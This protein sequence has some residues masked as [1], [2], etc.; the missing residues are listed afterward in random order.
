MKTFKKLMKESILQSLSEEDSYKGGHQKDWIIYDDDLTKLFCIAILNEGDGWKLIE[1]V[2][3]F[4]N[5]NEILKMITIGYETMI[6]AAKDRDL[7]EYVIGK[8]TFDKEDV[9]TDFWH[10]LIPDNK[11]WSKASLE[12]DIDK[13]EFEKEM[14]KLV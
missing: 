9:D 11:F 6:K 13:K 3:V 14:S 5:K 10:D 12:I 8:H 1:F 7:Y 4:G 2:N